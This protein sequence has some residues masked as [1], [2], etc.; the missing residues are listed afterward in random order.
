MTPEAAAGT[1]RVRATGLQHSRPPPDVDTEHRSSAFVGEAPAAATECGARRSYTA[2]VTDPTQEHPRRL[3]LTSLM[4]PDMVNF[5][6][7]VHGGALLK[8]LDE[9][10]YSCAARYS[11]Q[12]V[13]TARL[14]DA[15]FRAPVHVG[16]LVT[17]R[18]CINWVGRTSM[19][20]G[21]RVVAEN[22]RTRSQRHVMSCFF[23][24]VAMDEE[25]G[26]CEAPRFE[27]I[28][29]DDRRRWDNAELRRAERNRWRART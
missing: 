16:E 6:G 13:V 24:M 4:T 11:G 26:P 5:S 2:A 14:D 27:R 22:H 10:A 7:K 25:G 28:T 17:F 20:V 21:I 23:L 18:A 8:L 19:E 29:A 3:E 9:V 15:I 1:P 12:Y